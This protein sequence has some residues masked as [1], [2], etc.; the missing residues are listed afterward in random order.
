MR[1][2]NLFLGVLFLMACGL[3]TADPLGAANWERFRGPN[4]VGV[5]EDPGIPIQFTDKDF[6][7]KTAIP[8]VGNGSPIVWGD[9]L[10]LQAASADGKSRMMICIGTKDGNILWNRILPG[11]T[12]KTNA[13]GSLASSTPATDGERVYAYFWDGKNIAVHAWDFSGNPL[14]KYDLGAWTGNHGPG[15]SLV[16]YD[17]KV[18]LLDDQGTEFGD[19]GA[20]SEV[21]AI[22]AKSGKLAWKMVRKPNRA[23]YA[24]PMIV[25][26]STGPQLLIA[27]TEGLA[28]Y[29]PKDGKEIWHWDW[30]FDRMA[31]RTVGSPV[32]GSGLAFVGSGDGSG[33]RHMVAVKLGGKGDITKSGLA[34]E[35]K[36]SLPYVPS[37][38]FHKD[39]LYTINDKGI[40]GCYDAKSGKELWNQRIGAAF[41][42][43][44]V[45][46]NGNIY[47][48]GEDG[49]VVVIA[50]EPKFKKLGESRLT[51]PV[52]ASPAVADGRLY[53][54]GKNTLYAIGKK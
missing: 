10:F 15:A 30:K 14:W 40:A 11:N 23:C 17:G 33:A 42:A 7:W 9:K 46:I 44:P 34:W 12:A 47:A 26:E 35:E 43:S 53:V 45:L 19:K 48:I 31:L 6:V 50:A 32:I 51:E 25:Q 52:S 49:S 24:T 41:T 4:G 39:H 54:R 16:V 28:G 2:A 8:G 22:D 37:M 29:D 13:R 5:V 18:F 36:K 27:T 3:L 21:V 20:K 1:P 38:L